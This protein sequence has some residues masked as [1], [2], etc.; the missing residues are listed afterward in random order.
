MRTISS[1]LN[2]SSPESRW[3]HHSNSFVSQMSLNHGVIFDV[4]S[5]RM[6]RRSS[7]V[8]YFVAWTSLG[9]TSRSTLALM[10]KM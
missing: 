3:S 7:G 6:A 8:T 2:F 5:A 1:L 10:K 9:L 4:G